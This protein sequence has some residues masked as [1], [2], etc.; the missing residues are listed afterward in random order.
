LKTTARDAIARLARAAACALAFA[1][2]T[3]QQHLLMALI[4]DGTF[5]VLLSHLE[6]TS[7]TNRRRLTELEAQ[8]DW[9][10]MV[11]FAEE[12]LARDPSNSDWWMVKGYAYTRLGQHQQ[13]AQ[14]YSEMVRRAPD[15]M[16]GWNLL[17]ESQ[18]AMGQSARA[19][20]TLD[21]ALLIRRDS[22]ATWFVLG[23]SYSDLGRDQPAA[24]A[25]RQAVQLNRSFAQAWYG[26]G[27]VYARQ[28]Q[29]ADFEQV[30]RTLEQINPALAQQLAKEQAGA[31]TQ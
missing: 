16:L 31:P 15:E 8:G 17:A 29:R 26:L 2:C 6:T 11:T 4:P 21:N 13:A 7:D 12:N 3:P 23:E 22:A 30:V 25:Y 19:V 5:S 18:R 24:Q 28:G 9:K 10:G 14:C 1:G 27:R 20:Q